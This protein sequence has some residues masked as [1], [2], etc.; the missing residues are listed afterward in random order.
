VN[1]H[2]DSFAA[3]QFRS[4]R[5]AERLRRHASK[6]LVETQ[7]SRDGLDHIFNVVN[8]QTPVGAG[9]DVAK[10]RTTSQM[11]LYPPDLRCLQAG[12]AR[13]RRFRVCGPPVYMIGSPEGGSSDRVKVRDW[14]AIRT[15]AVFGAD[16]EP[17]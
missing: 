8:D 6:I 4:T 10:V 1:R 12:T 16:F 14:S 15:V 17:G 5:D 9:R 13:F 11:R 7:V 2:Q 3:L